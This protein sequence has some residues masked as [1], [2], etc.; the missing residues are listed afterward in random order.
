[1]HNY[2]YLVSPSVNTVAAATPLILSFQRWLNSDWAPFVT[3]SIEVF[4]GTSYVPIWSNAGEGNVLTTDSAWMPK[5][6]DISAHK[7]AGMRVR[8]G[9]SV[10]QQ[11]G[12]G[13]WIMSG[14]NIDDVLIAA[15]P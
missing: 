1:M 9:F 15:C 11:G 6:F 14:W 10:G 2:Y 4:N 5:S 13:P 3:N 7:N 8:F 12:F